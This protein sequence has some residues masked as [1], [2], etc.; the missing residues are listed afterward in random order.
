MLASCLEASKEEAALHADAGGVTRL[1]E[2]EEKVIDRVQAL[3]EVHPDPE[4]SAL[5]VEMVPRQARRRGDVA[6]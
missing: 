1:I 2:V 5:A 3:A 4:V 6:P